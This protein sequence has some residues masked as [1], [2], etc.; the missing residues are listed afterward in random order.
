MPR[1]GGP[2][3]AG[4][5]RGS[6]AGGSHHKGEPQQQQQAQQ[7]AAAKAPPELTPKERRAAVSLTSRVRAALE[8]LA[9]SEALAGPEVT[10]WVRHQ[11]ARGEGSG[12][13]AGEF[14]GTGTSRWVP[15]T[16]AVNAAGTGGLEMGHDHGAGLCCGVVSTSI[17]LAPAV[18]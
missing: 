6:Q 14:L 17:T 9:V 5:G 12:G 2:G 1:G 3:E 8:G 18:A 11:L 15:S 13:A 7:Q 16:A 4:L 10:A